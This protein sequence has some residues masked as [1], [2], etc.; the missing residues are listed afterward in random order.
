EIVHELRRNL[1]NTLHVAA[2]L[3][4][5]QPAGDLRSGLPAVASHLGTLP[6]HLLRDRELLVHD[7]RR[8]LLAR[9]IERCFPT[10]NSHLPRDILGE[11]HRLGRAV[12]HAEAG[13]RAAES[14]EAHAM[15]ALAQ[16]L[17]TL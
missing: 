16:D 14:E 9:E 10:R 15:A 7:R 1:G 6:Q 5:Q 4:V 2:V 3:R 17:I 8:T 12:L 11:L 13:N